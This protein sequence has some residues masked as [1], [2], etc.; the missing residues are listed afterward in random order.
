MICYI[1]PAWRESVLS[2]F[3]ALYKYNMVLYKFSVP[4]YIEFDI[5]CTRDIQRTPKE[6]QPQGLN[7][8]KRGSIGNEVS[9]TSYF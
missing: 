4:C 5:K 3:T 2:S 1:S 8:A 9:V 7:L 6:Q